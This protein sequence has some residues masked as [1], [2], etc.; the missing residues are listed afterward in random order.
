MEG[1][2]IIMITILLVPCC[3]V[4]SSRWISSGIWSIG[5][6]LTPSARLFSRELSTVGRVQAAKTPKTEWMNDEKPLRTPWCCWGVHR[7]PTVVA[8]TESYPAFIWIINTP[9]LGGSWREAFHFINGKESPGGA[10]LAQGHGGPWQQKQNQGQSDQPLTL[11][12]DP[13][14]LGKSLQKQTPFPCLNWIN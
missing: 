5:L 13:L 1:G 6:P 9:T 12:Q 4:L 8:R 3:R 10:M 2:I 11:E 7:I 14:S